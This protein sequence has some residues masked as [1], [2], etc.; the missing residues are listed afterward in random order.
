[1]EK[2][3]VNASKAYDIFIEAGLITQSGKYISECMES[4]RAAIVTDDTVSALHL[5]KLLNA[6]KPYA[7]QT[8][9]F[10]ISHGEQ[11]KNAENYIRLLNF[12]AENRINRK[13]MLIAFGG[14]VV[15][16]LAGFAAATYL[17]GI[18]FVQ[19]PTTLLACVDS[20][21][22]GKT[23]IDLD[24]GKNLAGAFYQPKLVLCDTNL[25]KTLDE[26]NLKSGMAEVIKYAILCDKLFFDKLKNGNYTTEEMIARCVQIKSDIVSEDEFD[27]GK[28]QLLNFG[29]TLGH[30]IEACSHFAMLHGIAV[31]AGM[32]LMTK[33]ARLNG[34]CSA[35]TEQAVYEILNKFHLPTETS[36]PF[37]PILDKLLS[38]KKIMAKTIN[39]IVP[40]EIGNCEI[41]PVPLDKVKSFLQKG[42]EKA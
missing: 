6:L 31:A 5:E 8:V 10:T 9:C 4:D 29:H 30:G 14:G 39:L 25:L 23:A 36:I 11:S 26:E 17:R 33:I 22:G 16:D 42:F 13:D 32:G 1:M 2:V 7:I 3:H 12:L 37:D 28:R 41:Y 27:T 40:R 19:I 21:V 34:L 24:A 20:S 15:G 35:E 18:S 38:D